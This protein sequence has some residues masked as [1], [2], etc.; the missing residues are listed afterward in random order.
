MSSGSKDSQKKSQDFTESHR[1]EKP[2]K[3]TPP[4]PKKESRKR[5]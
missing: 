4:K 1:P 5:K 3:P 2:P